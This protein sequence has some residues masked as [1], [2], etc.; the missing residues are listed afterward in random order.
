MVPKFRLSKEKK[1]GPGGRRAYDAVGNSKTD[2]QLN[3]FKFVPN[4]AIEVQN[5]Q[6]NSFKFVQKFVIKRNKLH[7]DRNYKKQTKNKIKIC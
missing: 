4:F 7:F 2:Q 5:V 3:Y 6:L 1:K